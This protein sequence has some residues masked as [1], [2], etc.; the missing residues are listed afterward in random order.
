MSLTPEII[1]AMLESGCTAEQ[2]AAVVKAALLKQE[3]KDQSEITAK[4]EAARLRKQKQ[5]EKENDDVTQCHA[6]SHDVTVTKKQKEKRTKKEKIKNIY[7]NPPKGGQKVPPLDEAVEKYNQLAE[8]TGLTRCLKLTET[9][10]AQ[11]RKRLEECG[12][13]SGWEAALEKLGDSAFLLG[14]NDRNWKVDFD[15]L[16]TQNKFTKLMEGG[17]DANEKRV[18]EAGAY[19]ADDAR[20]D[21]LRSFGICE[22][23][24]RPPESDADNSPGRAMLRYSEHLREEAGAAQD[25][26][27]GDDRGSE[28]GAARSDQ[29]GV[30]EMA[31]N[32]TADSDTV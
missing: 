3:Q 14:D 15:F 2:I 23:E 11:L 5:R 28:W 31:Q 21:A 16:I 26:Y 4:R 7:K 22:A 25:A 29:G 6:M 8:Q 27:A 12:G 18:N 32:I 9:R 13:L 17:Y 19:T 30:Y 10:K 24:G 1:D 20:R